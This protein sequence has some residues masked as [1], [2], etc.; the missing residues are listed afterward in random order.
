MQTPT[1]DPVRHITRAAAAKRV[2]RT[3]RTLKNWE[4]TKGLRA[5]RVNARLF[6]YDR[7]QFELIAQEVAP[8]QIASLP[9]E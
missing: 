2:R 4:A 1:L 8:L 7:L 6:V 5:I 3:T 9:A